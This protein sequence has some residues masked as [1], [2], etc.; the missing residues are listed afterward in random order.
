MYHE[1][2]EIESNVCLIRLSQEG[3]LSSKLY[4]EYI[5]TLVSRLKISEGMFSVN[6]NEDSY[7]L[8]CFFCVNPT[9]Y[10]N[11]QLTYFFL[12]CEYIVLTYL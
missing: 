5:Y 1:R 9:Y 8:R 12:M 10:K 3:R 6:I 2:G 7:K 4:K 11:F